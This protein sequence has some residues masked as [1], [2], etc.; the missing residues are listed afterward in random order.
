MRRERARDAERVAAAMA[1]LAAATHPRALPDPAEIWWRARVVERLTSRH[2]A[3]DRA[4]RP[5]AA[6]W[7]AAVAGLPLA[8]LLALAGQWR[9]LTR[10]VLRTE[11]FTLSVAEPL[12]PAVVIALLLLPVS[13]VIA[14]RGLRRQS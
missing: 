7:R 14:A 3:A 2:E 8:L 5:V 1:E 12:V 11:L 9:D 6:G 4:S 10:I 13:L